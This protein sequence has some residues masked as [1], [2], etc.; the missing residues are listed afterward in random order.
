MLSVRLLFSEL[1][2]SIARFVGDSVFEEIK[3]VLLTDLP[4]LIRDEI[5]PAFGKAR[6]DAQ[7]AN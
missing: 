2:E 6:K 1:A 7:E 5:D 3:K 4:G